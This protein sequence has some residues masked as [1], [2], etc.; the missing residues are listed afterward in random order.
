[1]RF[2]AVF[3]ST[4]FARVKGIATCFSRI[5][6]F[7]VACAL[8]GFSLVVGD[9]LIDIILAGFPFLALHE[10]VVGGCHLVVFVVE[11]KCRRLFEVLTTEVCLQ[12]VAYLYDYWDLVFADNDSL[13]LYGLDFRIPF[14][15]P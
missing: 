2:F 6:D 8:Q 14:V 12:L 1:M 15:L 13:Q 4:V 7:R 10:Q 11:D 9:L 5:C 3:L